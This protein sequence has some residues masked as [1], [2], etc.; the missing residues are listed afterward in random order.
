MG[1]VLLCEAYQGKPIKKEGM[2]IRATLDEG[3]RL[4]VQWNRAILLA[5]SHKLYP[6]PWD[7][8][9]RPKSSKLR[10]NLHGTILNRKSIDFRSKKRKKRSKESSW[11]GE[12][13]CKLGVHQGRVQPKD[14]ICFK[15]SPN[16]FPRNLNP[17]PPT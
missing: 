2:L 13:R 4:T 5:E 10:L 7:E 17:G 15:R 14:W 16:W 8:G 12:P 1:P 9:P 11:F 3:L 6:Q